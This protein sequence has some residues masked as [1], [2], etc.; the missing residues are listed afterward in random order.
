[1]NHAEKVPI[2]EKKIVC[3]YF[4]PEKF[5][6]VRASLLKFEKFVGKRLI[7]MGGPDSVFMHVSFVNSV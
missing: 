2:G 3:K 4:F 6:H 1:M 5:F 7:C